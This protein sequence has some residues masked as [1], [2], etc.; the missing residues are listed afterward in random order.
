MKGGKKVISNVE[1]FARKCER[2]D[3]FAH[4]ASS[5]LKGALE[6]TPGELGAV[7]FVTRKPSDAGGDALCGNFF[8]LFNRFP[9]Y[10]VR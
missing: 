1:M 9:F 10:E 2:M 3:S 6:H 7:P 4:L 8:E 5:I